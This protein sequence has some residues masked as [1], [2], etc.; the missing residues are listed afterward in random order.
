MTHELADGDNDTQGANFAPGP[1]ST[2][3][4]PINRNEGDDGK[5]EDSS[6]SE[7]NLKKP[8]KSTHILPYSNG[9]VTPR[10]Q[11]PSNLGKLLASERKV[12]STF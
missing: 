12:C 9:D 8:S 5:S 6:D 11:G 7:S 4:E 1:R 10:S 2:S 3:P